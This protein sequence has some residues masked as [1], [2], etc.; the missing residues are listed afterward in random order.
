MRLSIGPEAQQRRH[1]KE[2]TLKAHH[3]LMALKSVT[4]HAQNVKSNQ[5]ADD[6]YRQIAE[7]IGHIR[8][9]HSHCPPQGETNLNRFSSQRRDKTAP[10]EAALPTIM[11]RCDG[12]RRHFGSMCG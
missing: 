1:T 9:G 3:E 8:H 6:K 5:Q 4:E 11:P 2:T 12:N 7:N 10:E